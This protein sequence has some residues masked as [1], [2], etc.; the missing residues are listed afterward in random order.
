MG[1][2]V[3]TVPLASQLR[4][5]EVKQAALREH[6]SGELATQ[7][8]LSELYKSSVDEEKAKVAELRRVSIS[9]GLCCVLFVTV[10]EASHFQSCIVGNGS[11]HRKDAHSCT[12]PR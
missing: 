12:C 1:E 3:L 11:C 9:L 8:K 6:L 4:D 2:Q 7:T 10:L 5:S